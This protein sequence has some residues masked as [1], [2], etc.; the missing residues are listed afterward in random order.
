V[1]KLL[2]AARPWIVNDRTPLHQSTVAWPDLHNF[3]RSSKYRNIRPI[4][5]IFRAKVLRRASLSLI[6]VAHKTVPKKTPITGGVVR[7][8][9]LGLPYQRGDSQKG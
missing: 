6:P 4:G 5:G 7:L 2:R 9:L 3:P 8:R 1:T